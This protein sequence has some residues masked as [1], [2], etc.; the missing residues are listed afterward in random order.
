MV[1]TAGGEERGLGAIS[2]DDVEPH[3][4]PVERHRSL[5][6]GDL[7]MDVADVG[8]GRNAVFS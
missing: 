8:L 6:I 3:Y 4:V 7:E 5:E 2:H 1:I